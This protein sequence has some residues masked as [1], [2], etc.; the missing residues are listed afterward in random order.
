VT[1]RLFILNLLLLF[2]VISKAGPAQ[3]LTVTS[4]LEYQVFQR[5]TQ[6]HGTL[7]LAGQ[8][9][10]GM[11]VEYHLSGSSTRGE[12]PGDWL[13][14]S[15]DKTS[16]N[17]DVNVPL[18]AGGWYHLEVRSGEATATIRHVGI[19]EVFVI[20]G[21][22]NSTN[23]GSEKQKP[24]SGEVVSFDGQA[25]VIA[26]DPQPGTQDHSKGGSFAPAFGDAMYAAL[27][28]PIA[29]A[30]TGQGSSSVRQ[31]L[32]KGELMS[33]APTILKY[34]EPAGEGQWKSTGKLFDGLTARL[35][36]LGPHGYRAILWH[37]GESD[38]GQAR[39]GYPAD[40]QITGAQYTDFMKRLIAG[41]RKH[42]GWD[43]PWFVAIATYHSEKDAADEEFRSAQKSLCDDRFI[44]AGPDTDTLGKDYRAGVHFNASGLQAHGRLWAFQVIPWIQSQK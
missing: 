8:A 18:P 1:P 36:A 30:S 7:R 12:L 22:S 6:T 37:Q 43:I 21:Q 42:A 35:D 14:I 5:Q 40:R 28:V 20:A 4:P 29:I 26:D 31:W 32:A 27:K 9:A 15:R 16:E 44:L 2:A 17:F 41:T 38:A 23:H 3:T 34:V 24:T 11:P 39:A 19:G 13:P 10:P 25:W 33:K